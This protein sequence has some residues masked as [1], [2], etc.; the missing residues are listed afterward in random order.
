MWF[1]NIVSAVSRLTPVTPRPPQTLCAFRRTV[2][3][4]QPP[5]AEGDHIGCIHQHARR[6]TDFSTHALTLAEKSAYH[7]A[8]IVLV[9]PLQEEIGSIEFLEPPPS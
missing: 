2:R 4:L 8:E 3:L 1:F 9:Q 5:H 6:V 7:G